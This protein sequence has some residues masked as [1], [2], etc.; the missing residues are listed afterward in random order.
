M[1][2]SRVNKR[3]TSGWIVIRQEFRKFASFGEPEAFNECISD[4]AFVDMSDRGYERPGRSGLKAVSEVVRFQCELSHQCAFAR[5]GRRDMNWSGR[6][7]QQMR[8]PLAVGSPV[9]FDDQA[10][11][12]S[13]EP[14]KLPDL[15]ATAMEEPFAAMQPVS[16]IPSVHAGMPPS[17]ATRNPSGLTVRR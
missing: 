3:A 8:R 14:Y 7:L 12:K 5:L 13:S 15:S 4:E 9:L 6:L 10:R 11:P 1:G 16:M 2:A 17:T